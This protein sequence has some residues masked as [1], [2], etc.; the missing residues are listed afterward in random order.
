LSI[1]VAHQLRE[2]GDDISRSVFPEPNE[3][4]MQLTRAGAVLPRDIAHKRQLFEAVFYELRV[5]CRASHKNIGEL[6]EW[7]YPI[8]EIYTFQ[9]VFFSCG[10]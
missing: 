1:A 8:S 5:L 9:G 6:T 4:A 3:P 10:R 2:H 7:Q